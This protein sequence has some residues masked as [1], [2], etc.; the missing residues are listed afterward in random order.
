ME[1]YDISDDIKAHPGEYLLHTPSKQVV[2][3]GAFNRKEGKIKALANGK[4]IEDKIH[5]FQ[6]IKLNKEEQKTRTLKR[7]CGG[8]KGR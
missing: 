2:V 6:K 8:C 3:C 7:G 5:N 4:L 1:F